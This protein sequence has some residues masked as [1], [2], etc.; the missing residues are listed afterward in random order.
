[1]DDEKE[2]LV[3]SLMFL[4]N[5]HLS[6]SSG[7][8]V[9]SSFRSLRKNS[10]SLEEQMSCTKGTVHKQCH[11]HSATVRR[12]KL[13]ILPLKSICIKSLCSKAK[14]ETCI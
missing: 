10:I 11:N 6:M 3:G 14:D 1:M 8:G 13:Q 5:G 4:K 7:E 12:C 9:D 2:K